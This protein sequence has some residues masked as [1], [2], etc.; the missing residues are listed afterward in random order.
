MIILVTALLA[1]IGTWFLPWW[2]IAVIPFLVAVVAQLSSRRG[3]KIG[4][5]SIVLLWLVVI[6][7]RDIP[8]DH[9]LSAR[10]AKLFSL[11]HYSLF[12]IVSL[13]IGGII[14]GLAGWAGGAMNKAFRASPNPSQGGA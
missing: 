12:I 4:F 10:M 8:N 11:P 13:L 14:G 7:L 9:I 5:W 6:L 3:F 2:M 1:G